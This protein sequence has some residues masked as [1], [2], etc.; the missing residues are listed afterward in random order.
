M[1]ESPYYLLMKEK[2]IEAEESLKI[3]R[4]SKNVEK[5]LI[6]LTD[7][8]RRQMSETG[9]YKDLFLI[10]AN[11]KA[12][13]LAVFMRCYQ[14]FAGAA[15][16][17][18][19]TQVLIMQTTNFSPAVGSILLFVIRSLMFIP[20]YFLIDRIGR[21]V[22][23]QL[24]A[25]LDCVMLTLLGT[26]FVLNDYFY[27]DMTGLDWFPLFIITCFMCVHGLG[28]ADVV[29]V[30]ISE[31]FSSSIKSKA[32]G[33]LSIIFACIM[34]SSVKMYQYTAYNFST[35]IPFFVFASIT[36]INTLISY[37]FV[38]ETKGKTLEMI[39]QGL[40]KEQRS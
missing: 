40:R 22:L 26:Y 20:I 6:S 13:F 19:Y 25:S 28:L 14:Q 29:A 15:T 4:R 39:Q 10:Y 37:K 3:L 27:V 33:L 5:E 18:V 31:I 8:V 21:K 24:S 36:L 11:R 34:I 7:D 35:A 38:P 12:F 2:Q 30:Y 1:P 16:I 32:L 23:I 17:A 9:T